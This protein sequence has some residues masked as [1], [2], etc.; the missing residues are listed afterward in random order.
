MLVY[1]DIIMPKS[2]QLRHFILGN[3]PVAMVSMD[4][5]LLIT[6]FNRQAEKLTGFTAEE[7]LGQPCHSIFNSSL[8]QEQCPLRTGK[9]INDTTGLIAEFTNRYHEHIP[10]RIGTATINNDQ[11][12]FLGYL[13]VIDDISREKSLE[14]EKDNFLFMVAHDMKSPLIAI[15]GLINRIRKRHDQMSPEQLEQYLATINHAAEQLEAQVHDFLHL[16]HQASAQ[17][18]LHQTKVDIPKIINDLV[19]RHRPLADKQHISITQRHDGPGQ[20]KADGLQLQRAFENLLH[21]AIKFCPSQGHIHIST[22]QTTEEIIIEF[23]D[24]GPGIAPKEQPFIF[25]AFYQSS[26]QNRGQGLGLA[27]VK[28]IIHEHGGRVSVHSNPGEG[29]IF[30]IRLPLQK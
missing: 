14:R 13:E 28:A 18:S 15:Q 6:S 11:G 19:E 3:I 8:C 29:A 10:V 21:N 4:K 16:S 30:T 26:S 20:L 27:A 22:R 1:L 12:E 5:N 2:S 7:A 9:K 24:N 25:D 23:H 17:I